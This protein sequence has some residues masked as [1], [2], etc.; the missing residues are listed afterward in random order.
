VNFP[1]DKS[2]FIDTL[3]L[4]RDSNW[5]RIYPKFGFLDM[6]IPCFGLY[7]DNWLELG[8]RFENNKRADMID[9][10]M[11]N[12]FAHLDKNN[13]RMGIVESVCA[14]ESTIKQ[15]IPSLLANM[16]EPPIPESLLGKAVEEMGFRLT[17]QIIFEQLSKK[18]GFDSNNCSNCLKAIEIR[19]NIIHNQQRAISVNDARQYVW[20][21]NQ[22][23]NSI[24]K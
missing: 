20:A 2:S 11:A 8:I 13:A 3:W 1:F 16:V 23:I 4:D 7:R 18:L 22:I 5:K 12:A 19:N 24:K 14:L 9:T 6:C 17:T 10:M 15:Y 21:I